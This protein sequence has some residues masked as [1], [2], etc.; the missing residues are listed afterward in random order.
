MAC[1][2]CGGDGGAGGHGGHGD[3]GLSLAH[4]AVGRHDEAAAAAAAETAAEVRRVRTASWGGSDGRRLRSKTGDRDGGDVGLLSSRRAGTFYHARAFSPMPGGDDDTISVMSSNARAR[5][6]YPVLAAARD[7]APPALAMS[8]L[9]RHLHRL[10]F[11]GTNSPSQPLRLETR[12]PP[13]LAAAVSDHEFYE[14]VDDVGELGR[15][16][17]WE[18]RIANLLRATYHPIALLWERARRK[19][20]V[21]QLAK[22]YAE[23]DHSFLRNTRARALGNCVKFGYS[24]DYTLAW[25]DVL[26]S[27]ANED[28]G[29]APVGKPHIPAALPLAGDGSFVCPYH[30]E[31]SDPLNVAHLSLVAP[32]FHSIILG[33]NNLLRRFRGPTLSPGLRLA[34]KV[35]D[36]AATSTRTAAQLRLLTAR[37]SGSFARTSMYGMVIPHL[38]GGS[39]SP[40]ADGG[41][42]GGGGV[43]M[44][45]GGGGGGG[46]VELSGPGVGMARTDTGGLNT[47]GGVGSPTAVGEASGGGM[48]GAGVG[49]EGACCGGYRQNN[50]PDMEDQRQ[51]R[52]VDEY[53]RTVNALLA[54]RWREGLAALDVLKSAQR[55]G[56]LAVTTDRTN[57]FVEVTAAEGRKWSFPLP[58][59]KHSGSGGVI[60]G[61]LPFLTAPPVDVDAM[62]PPGAMGTAAHVD[63]DEIDRALAALQQRC[64]RCRSDSPTRPST[65]SWA[66]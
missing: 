5:Q 21:T 27:D 13:E 66:A 57:S 2:C 37:D 19:A 41:G 7:D 44:A 62:E 38:Q 40:L 55:A 30:V 42:G 47:G 54:N 45:L 64:S 31:L 28:V 39:T 53:I 36:D 25:I 58:R 50:A 46:G 23:F 35:D 9:G 10:F 59:H 6:P 15:W 18:V 56:A 48:D 8:E 61:L 16:K 63:E 65:C 24:R 29:G 14:H 11:I 12:I 32:D 33:L 34:P 43:Y 52:T 49:D 17:W 20:H 51:L 1:A 60:A 22:R 4:T 26:V 3:E